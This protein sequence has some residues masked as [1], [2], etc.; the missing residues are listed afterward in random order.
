[1]SNNKNL[2]QKSVNDIS[3]IN[4]RN[5][6]VEAR[7]I[8]TAP[9]PV[10]FKKFGNRQLT[11]DVKRI[12][13]I[14]DYLENLISAGQSMV[15][16]NV[17]AITSMEKIQLLAQTE[18][19]QLRLNA[20]KAKNNLELEDSNNEYDFKKLQNNITAL[21]YEIKSK[22]LTLN[23]QEFELKR[24]QEEHKMNMRER[25]HDLAERERESAQRIKESDQQIKENELD[26][27]NRLNVSEALIYIEKL[28]A[29]NESKFNK[30]FITLYNKISQELKLENITPSQVLILISLFSKNP[31]TSFEDVDMRRKKFEEELKKMK[32]DTAYRRS[33]VKNKRLDNEVKVYKIKKEELDIDG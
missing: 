3:E 29:N 6:L 19:D 11:E 12:G 33:E 4:L 23:E 26:S 2:P 31:A 5:L 14:N 10:L 27:Q 13:L 22:Q 28:K 20:K 24:K 8:L 16:L 18:L 15:R 25:E 9:K 30:S 17:D 32:Q 7:D 21:N 1:M